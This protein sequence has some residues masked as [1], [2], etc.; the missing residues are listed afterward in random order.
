VFVDKI[1]ERGGGVYQEHAKGNP[2]GFKNDGPRLGDLLFKFVP[3]YFVPE[4][5]EQ[6][7]D[8]IR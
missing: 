5:L 2:E 6:V 7:P 3:G 4:E 1:G 8:Q